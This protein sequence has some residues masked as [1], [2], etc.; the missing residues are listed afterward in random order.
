[1][2]R[3]K[4]IRNSSLALTGVILTKDIFKMRWQKAYGY[5]GMLYTVDTAWS[6]CDTQQYPVNDCHEML[7]YWKGRI[8]LVSNATHYNILMYDDNEQLMDRRSH[9]IPS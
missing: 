2:Q 5:N 9:D 6:K 3:R 8:F 1:M 7:Q 4:F